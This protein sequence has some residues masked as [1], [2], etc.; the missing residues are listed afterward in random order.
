M[1]EGK[2]ECC[3]AV[4]IIMKASIVVAVPLNLH[5]GLS[6]YALLP[7][8]LSTLVRIYCIWGSIVY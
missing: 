6:G 3:G 1:K 8:I 5:R 2:E 7:L 4:R